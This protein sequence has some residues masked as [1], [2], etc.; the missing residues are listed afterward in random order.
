VPVPIK[1]QVDQDLLAPC[2]EPD[3]PAPGRSFEQKRSAVIDVGAK[4]RLCASKHAGLVKAIQPVL[5]QPR[6]D[7][8]R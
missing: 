5:D 3:R 4:F 1:V 8:P 2:L 6:A 7:A